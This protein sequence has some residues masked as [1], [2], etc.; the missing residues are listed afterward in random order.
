MSP[1]RVTSTGT[2]SL[3]NGVPDWVYEEEVFGNDYSLWWSPDSSKIAFLR[4][5]ETAVDEY[6][7]PIYNPTDDAHSVIPYPEDVTIK[8][9]KPGY[10][11]PIASVHVFDLTS[12]LEFP[13]LLSVADTTFELEWAG[14][15]STNNS[16]IS[17][18][19]W[20]DNSTLIVKEVNR[21]ADQGGII[22]FN[23][24]ML[25]PG[26]IA[27]GEIVRRLGKHGEEGDDGWI[28]PVGAALV[29]LDFAIHCSIGPKYLSC[30]TLAAI[31]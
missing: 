5:D 4:L 6:H 16:I 29:A 11:N 14:R 27:Y 21:A 9:P 25:A 8:Y 7:F 22:F 28:D 3:F 18:V 31:R 23:F 10:D 30:P 19:T 20:V 2:A 15:L 1:I 24:E 26:Q 17:Q 12:Y 13:V